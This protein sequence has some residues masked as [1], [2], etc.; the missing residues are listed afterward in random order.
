M[1][2]IDCYQ[3]VGIKLTMTLKCNDQNSVFAIKNTK[4]YHFRQ[5]KKKKAH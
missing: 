4:I 3:N 5:K 1:D 2:Q